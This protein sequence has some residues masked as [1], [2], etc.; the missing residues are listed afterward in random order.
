MSD[1]EH[2][3]I[4]DIDDARAEIERLR[5]LAHRA[6]DAASRA[7]DAAYGRHDSWIDDALRDVSR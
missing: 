7:E 3:L 2:E 5:A 1:V 6:L 4:S